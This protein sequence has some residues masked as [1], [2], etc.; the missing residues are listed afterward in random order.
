MHVITVKNKDGTTKAYCFDRSRLS[1][2]FE[3]LEK[4][5]SDSIEY[6]HTFED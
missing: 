4:L 6:N 2:V 5:R 1:E 3:L